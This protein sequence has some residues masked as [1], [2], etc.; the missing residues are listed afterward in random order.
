MFSLLIVTIGFAQLQMHKK[1]Y[2]LIRRKFQSN[3]ENNNYYSTKQLSN[4]L[5]PMLYSCGDITVKSNINTL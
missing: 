3:I 5:G 1:M 4:Q 2:R